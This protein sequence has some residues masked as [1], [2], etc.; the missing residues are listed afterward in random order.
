MRVC[1]CACACACVY[2]C[3]DEFVDFQS[4]EMMEKQVGIIQIKYREASESML[5]CCTV[6]L[7]AGKNR[8]RP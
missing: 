3:S 5:Y 6:E 2:A 8:N 7:S 1:A 4:F